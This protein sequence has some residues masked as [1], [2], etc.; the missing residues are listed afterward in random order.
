MSSYSAEIAE[1]ERLIADNQFPGIR[2][3]LNQHV[4]KLKEAERK[5]LSKL[6]VAAE[7]M[8][9]TGDESCS[10]AA[11]ESKDG[12]ASAPVVV[13]S[14]R[15]IEDFA[16]DQGGYNSPTISIFIDLPGVGKVKDQV[17]VDFTNSSF[18]LQVT[19]LE[20]KNYRLYKDNLEKDIVAADS[21]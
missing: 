10:S 8:N 2:A 21:K 20:G 18:D 12:P 19:G 1:A 3:C 11:A 15:P 17:K 14:F 9:I 7:A 13:G 4:A 6:S 16:W 5:E